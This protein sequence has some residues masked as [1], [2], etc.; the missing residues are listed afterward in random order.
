MTEI[1]EIQF[2]IHWRIGDQMVHVLL[3]DSHSGEIIGMMG[4]ITRKVWD[5]PI[6]QTEVKQI[7]AAYVQRITA[8]VIPGNAIAGK[9]S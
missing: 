3:C 5:D 9:D 1:V 6:F 8:Q 4:M 2:N 7:Y